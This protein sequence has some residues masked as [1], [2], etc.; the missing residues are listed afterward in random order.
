MAHVPMWTACFLKLES[1][2]LIGPGVLTD[3]CVV[4]SVLCL[5]WLI[6]FYDAVFHFWMLYSITF[7]VFCVVL[8]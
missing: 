6:S 2:S 1:S 5:G 8:L 3:G 7:F 4:D